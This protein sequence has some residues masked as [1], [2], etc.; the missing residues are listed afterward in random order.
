MAKKKNKTIKFWKQYKDC[1]VLG[2]AAEKHIKEAD[3]KYK[4]KLQKDRR[5]QR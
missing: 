5:K 2:K 3:K 4:R 1:K